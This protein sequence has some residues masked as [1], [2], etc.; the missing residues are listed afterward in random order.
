MIHYR[1]T[2]LKGHG[3]HRLGLLAAIG[4]APLTVMLWSMDAFGGGELGVTSAVIFYASSL[5]LCLLFA[6]GMAWAMKGFAVR[7][8]AEG[9]EDEERHGRPA[10]AHA[11]PPAG[12]AGH[13][14]GKAAAPHK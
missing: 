9:E 7:T 8:K 14:H 12:A 6:F 4:F 3:W 10:A 2:P 11:G 5:V 1:L 13:G